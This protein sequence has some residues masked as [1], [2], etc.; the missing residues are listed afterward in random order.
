M[1]RLFKTSEAREAKAVPAT[2]FS[3]SIG[4]IKA[5]RF[6]DETTSLFTFNTGLVCLLEL[7]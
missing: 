5:A 1:E 4:K 2:L 6:M 3:T 7:I